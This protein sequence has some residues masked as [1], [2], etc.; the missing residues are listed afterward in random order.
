MLVTRYQP[1]DVA[2]VPDLVRMIRADG[3]RAV[4]VLNT[5]EFP[6]STNGTLTDKII[7][8]AGA[9]TEA[10]WPNLVARIDRAHFESADPDGRVA[11]LNQHLREIATELDVTVL[12]RAEYQCDAAAQS[13][14][15]IGPRLAKY[16]YD[17]G[18][19]TT[20]GAAFFAQR[21]GALQ[22][23]DPAVENKVAP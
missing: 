5:V 16:F 22:W 19:T 21:I 10:D 17:Y 23:L 7:A 1:E 15:A 2:A 8:R 11:P 18:H 20:D 3:K 9:L 6:G 13:C 14:F 12:D 4:I